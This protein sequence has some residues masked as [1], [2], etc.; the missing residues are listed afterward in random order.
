[1]R[2]L[3]VG[4]TRFVGRKMVES[5]LQRGHEVTLFNRGKTNPGA[6][7]GTEA[8]I[9]DRTADLGALQGRE[10]DAVIDV[11]GY[12]PKAVAPLCDLLR[13]RV[14]RYVFI[15]TISV[16]S[17]DSP[18]GLTEETGVLL[19]NGDPAADALDMETYGG[20]KVLC[21][22]VVE[23]VFGV[24]A[25]IVRP[26]LVVGPGDHSDRFTY[27]PRR[28]MRPG[29]FLA[30]DCPEMPVQVVDGRDLGDFTLLATERALSGAYHVAGPTPP[31]LFGD[32]VRE[33]VAVGGGVARPVWV[34]CEYLVAN[35]VAPWTDLPLVTSLTSERSPLST[36]DNT[37]ALGAGLTLRPITQTV[38]DTV[39]W[40]KAER[41][42][43]DPK[44]GLSDAREL[45]L[46]E[47]AKEEASP[48]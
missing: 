8:L 31:V 28:F 41:E 38:L 45:E 9:G 43:S 33:G 16:Y 25:L 39:A 37:K 24:R 40:W 46:I 7:E 47:G 12:W 32:F 1:M 35:G 17:D 3:F 26:G 13:D 10:W 34:P 15:S 48:R 4:G 2:L 18:D 19:E 21:E 14:G 23:R 42:G 36:V 44:W 30:P 20:L 11:C 27:W 6:F 22:R 5:A 29:P